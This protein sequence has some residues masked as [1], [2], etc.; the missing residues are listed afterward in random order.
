M[1]S[2]PTF[3][4]LGIVVRHPRIWGEA[5][6]AAPSFARRGWWRKPPFLPLPDPEYV[7]WRVATAYG[8]ANGRIPPDDIV[9]YLEWRRRQRS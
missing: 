7:A 1:K 5:M 8:S 3:A 6:R 2:V 4:L 9:A